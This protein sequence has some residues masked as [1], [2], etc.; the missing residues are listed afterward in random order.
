MSFARH[1]PDPGIPSRPGD[2]GQMAGGDPYA[3][4]RGVPMVRLSAPKGRPYQSP[5]PTNGECWRTPPGRQADVPIIKSFS[6]P[7]PYPRRKRIKKVRQRGVKHRDRVGV[8]F[9][10]MIAG[11]HL[12]NVCV[13]L[14][15][16]LI[17]A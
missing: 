11:M 6:A 5:L 13:R 10:L 2:R 14:V 15:S 9:A 12:A 16:S 1:D 17:T 4:L 3:E 7:M 8:Q